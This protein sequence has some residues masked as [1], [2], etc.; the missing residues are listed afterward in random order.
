MT[1]RL[2]ILKLSIFFVVLSFTTQISAQVV[3]K[4]PLEMPAKFIVPRN[5]VQIDSTSI[6]RSGYIWTVL[7]DRNDN[8]TYKDT[9]LIESFKTIDY[10][11][12][13]YVAEDKGSVIRIVRDPELVDGEFGFMAEDYGWI[14]KKKMLLW[15]HCLVSDQYETNIKGLVQNTLTEVNQERVEQG[16]TYFYNPALK[17]KSEKLSRS[18]EILYLYKIEGNSILLGKSVSFF[19]EYAKENLFGWIKKNNV[20]TWEHNIALEVNWDKE[21]AKERKVKEQIAMFFYD[22]PRAKR[23]G[24]GEKLNIKLIFWDKDTYDKRPPGDIWRFPLIELDTTSNVIKASVFNSTL[25][26]GNVLHTLVPKFSRFAGAFTPLKIEGH[27]YPLYNFV[28][29]FSKQELS[30]INKQYN[31]LLQIEAGNYDLRN[32]LYKYWHQQIDNYPIFKKMSLSQIDSMTFN[33]VSKLIYQVNVEGVLS[34]YRLEQLVNPP[35]IDDI[36]INQ[37]FETLKPK[38]KELN[39]IFNANN[40]EFGFQSFDLYYYWIDQRLLPL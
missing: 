6:T 8:Q 36:T 40:Y 5:T 31:Q 37:Y 33:D 10:L 13:F 22:K 1:N 20:T 29:M 23:Y 21:A 32:K 4:K 35:Y 38:Q 30:R 25:K 12:S 3:G 26:K 11:S 34:S 2:V 7:S 19:H 27:S 14:D 39:E 17:S 15:Q 28:L 16:V 18:Y 24:E 9:L